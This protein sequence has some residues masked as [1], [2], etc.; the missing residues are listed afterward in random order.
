MLRSA[1]NC[2]LVVIAICDIITMSSYLLYIIKFEFAA[3]SPSYG[4]RTIRFQLQ[5][6]GDAQDARRCNNCAA[7]YH[8][9]LLR[10][11]SYNSMER[12]GQIE[13]HLVAAKHILEAAPNRLGKMQI[14]DNG[15]LPEENRTLDKKMEK[16]Y[17]WPRKRIFISHTIAFSSN[18]LQSQQKLVEA[19][20]FSRLA[21]SSHKF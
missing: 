4:V 5:L 13:E 21:H 14:D 11:I 9:V 8:A 19:P 17:I 3:Q 2:V 7:W 16:N 15:N 1:V 20:S 10:N 6:G 18:L 12:P